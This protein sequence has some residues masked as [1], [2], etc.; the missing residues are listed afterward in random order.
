M[1]MIVRK[2]AAILMENLR[3]RSARRG[4]LAGSRTEKGSLSSPCPQ[5]GAR[6]IKRSLDFVLVLICQCNAIPSFER[7]CYLSTV[8]VMFVG[9][10]RSNSNSNK[11]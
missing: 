10:F 6:G 3:L 5:P 11:Q 9:A 2:N 4:E 7:P 8:V 1:S